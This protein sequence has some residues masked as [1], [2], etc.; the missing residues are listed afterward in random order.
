MATIEKQ[1]IH[2]DIEGLTESLRTHFEPFQQQANEWMEKAQGLSVT[3]A[4]QVEEM[5]QA[6]EARLALR[7][8]RIAIDKKHKDLKESALREGQTL[9]KIKRT[10]T[11]MIEPIESHLQEQEDFVKIQEANIRIERQAE[12]VALIHPYIGDLARQME[13]GD[14]DNE[15]FENFLLGQ[16]LASEQKEAE[17]KRQEIERIKA[18]KKK[19]DDDKKIREENERLRLESQKAEAK[20]KKEREARQALERESREREEKEEA[21]R[22]A[23]QADERKAKRAPDR[24]KLI[25]FSNQIGA[26]KPP[27]VKDEQTQ[28][29]ID[30]AMLLLIKVEKYIEEN[31]ERL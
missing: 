30:N 8:I 16:R 28:K 10:L 24:E 14:M 13:L 18:E 15:A 3:S 7:G 27:T 26:I 17:I 29:I 5:Q 1:L 25:Q 19:A 23:K 31:A 4:L 12:R 9:D 6:R 2:L 21:D 11:G 20:L 22:K